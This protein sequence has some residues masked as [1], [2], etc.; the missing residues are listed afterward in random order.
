LILTKWLPDG[1][2]L[3]AGGQKGSVA[4]KW[5]EADAGGTEWS[6]HPVFVLG[7]G[8]GNRAGEIESGRGQRNGMNRATLAVRYNPAYELNE[9]I[10]R[11][12]PVRHERGKGSV[13]ASEAN[14]P[15][16]RGNTC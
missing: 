13:E 8:E 1:K 11:P 9:R 5:N 4:R 10:K 3:E 15:G 6:L 12:V 2:L 14:V 7:S 16:Y